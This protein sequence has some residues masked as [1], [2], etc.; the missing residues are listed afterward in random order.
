M[1]KDNLKVYP[2]LDLVGTFGLY[3]AWP[4]ID[5]QRIDSE[6]KEDELDDDEK[7]DYLNLLCIDLP[8]MIRE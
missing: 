1:T 5:W 3:E 7:M 8:G 4:E 2:L 6:I